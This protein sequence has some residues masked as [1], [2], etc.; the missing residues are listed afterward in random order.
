MKA[1]PSH[2]PLPTEG[3]Q[4]LA[5]NLTGRCGQAGPRLSALLFPTPPHAK[6]S[7]NGAGGQLFPDTNRFQ[8]SPR[9]GQGP[10]SWQAGPGRLLCRRP[11]LWG[12]DPTIMSGGDMPTAGQDSCLRSALCVCESVCLSLYCPSFIPLFQSLRIRPPH[13]GTEGL[14]ERFCLSSPRNFLLLDST[15]Q[16]NDPEVTSI[17]QVGLHFNQVQGLCVCA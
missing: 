1:T 7:S 14:Q 5:P 4:R 15:G 3:E 13:L 12:A 8:A 17:K 16:I 10:S 2:P 6:A 11:V 9:R